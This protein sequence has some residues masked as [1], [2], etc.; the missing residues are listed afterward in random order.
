MLRPL[1]IS[2]CAQSQLFRQTRLGN[3]PQGLMQSLHNP[4]PS[5]GLLC[6]VKKKKPQNNKTNQQTLNSV[7]SSDTHWAIQWCCF[8]RANRL[9]CSS[10]RVL[11][12]PVWLCPGVWVWHRLAL[13]GQSS[14]C[15]PAARAE[16]GTQLMPHLSCFSSIPFTYS[17]WIEGPFFLDLSQTLNI[18]ISPECWVYFTNS[19]CD[20]F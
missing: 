20:D 2:V 1:L 6:T 13:Q 15:P 10:C 14:L 7:P 17:F 12:S 8:R 3:V 5:H 4:I 16:R 9:V 19:F 18:P 11:L